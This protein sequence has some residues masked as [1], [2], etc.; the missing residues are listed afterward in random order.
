L[1]VAQ[2][3]GEG[4]SLRHVIGFGV[5][6]DTPVGPLRFNFTDALRKEI[7]DREQT[8]DLTLSTSF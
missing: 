6:W 3:N 7:Y 1:G 5:L 4:G 8:F 2:L